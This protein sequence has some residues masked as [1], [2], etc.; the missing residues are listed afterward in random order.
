VALIAAAAAAHAADEAARWQALWARLPPLPAH[1]SEAARAISARPLRSEGL[2]YVQLRV[3]IDDERLKSLQR[4]IDALFDLTAKAHAAQ[5]QRA[6]DAVNRDPQLGELARKMS[7]A[8]K[9]DP[10]RPDAMPSLEQ[11]RQLDREVERVL[12]PMP[13]PASAAQERAA[14]S[15]IAAYKLELQRATPR[16]GQFMQ[17]LADQQ[18]GYLRQHAAVDRD[19]VAQRAAG[20]DAALLA[21]TVVARHQALAQQQLADANAIH[22]EARAALGPRV[23]RYIELA[24]AAEQRGVP[25]PQRHEAYAAI[26]SY[27]ELLLTLQRETLLDV[28]FWAGVRPAAQPAALYEHA[29]APGFDLRAN[30]EPLLSTTYYPAGRAIMLDRPPGIR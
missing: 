12:G 5:V 25:A 6:I 28:G 29:L 21:R 16:A 2:G 10:A 22:D 3:D 4:D 26:K 18:R 23:Q 20:A 19:A 9:P 30:G 27:I 24:Q 17:R 15:E 13:T 7:E 14:N 11:M 8:W 1:A